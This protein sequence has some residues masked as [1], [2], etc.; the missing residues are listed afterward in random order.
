MRTTTTKVEIHRGLLLLTIITVAACSPRNDSRQTTLD[1][2]G[3]TASQ[4]AEHMTGGAMGDSDHAF[5]DKMVNHHEGLIFL[6]SRAQKH[7]IGEVDTDARKLHMKQRTEQ[8]KMMQMLSGHG[9]EAVKP[10]LMPKH[11]AM[12]DSL[13][14]QTGKAYERGFYHDVIAHHQEGMAM[15]DS[16]LPRLSDDSIRAMAQKMRSDQA[17]EIEEFKA[18][19]SS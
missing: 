5:L 14:R 4:D 9:G 15:I 11:K 10:Q 13:E 19:A 3:D 16:F 12:S 6:A 18:K 7:D 8:Q 17:K 2:A 1:R